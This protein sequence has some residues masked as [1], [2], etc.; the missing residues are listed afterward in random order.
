V[1]LPGHDVLCPRAL[2]GQ[3][4][5]ENDDRGDEDTKKQK[6]NNDAD[7][8]DILSFAGSSIVREHCTTCYCQ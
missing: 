1:F 5:V 4:H 2:L 3:P 6:L 8:H 7:L